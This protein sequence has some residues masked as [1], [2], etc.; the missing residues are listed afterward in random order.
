MYGFICLCCISYRTT[1]TAFCLPRRG[2]TSRA[3]SQWVTVATFIISSAEYSAEPKLLI[4][5]IS[6]EEIL[7]LKI[8]CKYIETIRFF[9]NEYWW[10]LNFSYQLWSCGKSI[11]PS[12]FW[13]MPR[14][15]TTFCRFPHVKTNDTQCFCF[16][17]CAAVIDMCLVHE[18]KQC[19]HNNSK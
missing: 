1:W 4:P 13:Y 8:L 6:R 16:T 5:K 3:K 18:M 7:V 11:V 14:R 17:W 12:N 19:F 9:W 10:K 2:Q 15:L